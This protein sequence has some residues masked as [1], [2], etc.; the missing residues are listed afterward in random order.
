MKNKL[1]IFCL[2]LLF[3]GCAPKH[4]EWVAIGDSITYLNDHVDQTGNRV[5]KGYMTRVAE[6]LP[7]V[8]YVNHGYNG[9]TA[10][11]V[12]NKIGELGIQKADIYSV[13]LGTNDWWHGNPV[14]TLED[15]KNN[16]GTGTFA[17]AMRVIVMALRKLN[18]NAPIIL[19]TPMKRDDFV[20]VADMKNNAWGS[21]RDKNG[22][23]LASFAEMVRAIGKL[24]N[25]RVVDLFN[26]SGMTY[27]NLVKFKRLKDPQTGSYRDYPYPDFDGVPFNPATDEYPYPP[28]AI[29][30]T[31]DGLHPSDK[32]NQ[33]I[34]DMLAEEM[35]MAI[36]R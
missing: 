9:W 26:D 28:E 15:Y 20:Y 30:M 3:A 18:D 21:Y 35:K 4:T 14:G 10:V 7:E 36:G 33:I 23:S 31:Y 22:Q 19:I 8:H 16:S 5:T 6:Q 25:L 13:F 27:D 29:D 1:K 2:L 12:A 17:G 24:E 11:Q 34:A 32:G